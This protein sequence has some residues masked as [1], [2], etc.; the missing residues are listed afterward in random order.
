VHNFCGHVI[1]KLFGAKYIFLACI[2]VLALAIILFANKKR[3]KKK[4][5]KGKLVG[6]SDERR[7]KN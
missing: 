5:C 7:E 3:K 2:V 1:V 6:Y 4:S